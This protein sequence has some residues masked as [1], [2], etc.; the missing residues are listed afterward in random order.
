MKKLENALKLKAEA[1]LM[2]HTP[3]PSP[4]KIKLLVA[5]LV[6]QIVV[7]AKAVEKLEAKTH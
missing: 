1:D 5:D 7:L 3:I 2:L 6:D 4:L